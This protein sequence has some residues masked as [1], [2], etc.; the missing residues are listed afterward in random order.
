MEHDGGC[1]TQSFVVAVNNISVNGCQCYIY[2]KKRL[3]LCVDDE[4]N[5][6]IDGTKCNKEI[7]PMFSYKNS[8]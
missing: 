8:S 2:N 5:G 3:N 6:W 1:K 4:A 7:K